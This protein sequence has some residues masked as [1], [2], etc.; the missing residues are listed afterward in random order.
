MARRGINSRRNGHRPPMDTSDLLCLLSTRRIGLQRSR[1]HARVLHHRNWFSNVVG[2]L[3]KFILVF[4]HRARTLSGWWWWPR[5]GGEGSKT[6]K[7]AS[8][9]VQLHLKAFFLWRPAR[10]E[11]NFINSVSGER[12]RR[13]VKR[14]GERNARLV[15]AVAS[16]PP[17]FL[18][19]TYLNRDRCVY[20]YIYVCDVFFETERVSRA[21]ME[22]A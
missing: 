15:S 7:Y 20:I 12:E 18:C 10:N 14:A 1:R 5:R 11:R 21:M 13:S 4:A 6:L 9:R 22:L 16:A 19:L 2:A 17:L 8:S 3:P